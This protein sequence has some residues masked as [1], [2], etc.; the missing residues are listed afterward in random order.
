MG[1]MKNNIKKNNLILGSLLAVT[2]IITV[3]S[4]KKEATL[5]DEQKVETALDEFVSQLVLTPPTTTDLSGRIKDYMLINPTFFFGST[6]TLLDTLKIAT[7]SPY[8]YR[9]NN[10]LTLTADLLA[11]TS[12]HINNQLWLRQPID[13]GMSIWTNPYFDAGGGNIWMK[14][15]SVPVYVNGKIIAV[16]TTD[17]AL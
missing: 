1:K 11:D 17:L 13:G 3:A 10:T 4:C 12:Y 14:T 9:V 16:A 7:Y 8:W 15:R 2:L 5:T 6:V